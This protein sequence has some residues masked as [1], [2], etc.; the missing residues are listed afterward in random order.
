MITNRK[1]AAVKKTALK[2]AQQLEKSCDAMNA[3][4]RACR[5]AGLPFKGID[6]GRVLLRENMS[7]FHHYLRSV[8]D[9]E[10]GVA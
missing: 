6:D 3:Y 4:T 8:Y 10:G 5:D 2:L 7:E 9:K 1:D